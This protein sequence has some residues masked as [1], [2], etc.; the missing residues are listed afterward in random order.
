M[1]DKAFYRSRRIRGLC[2]QCGKVAPLWPDGTPK[3]KCAECTAKAK[4]LRSS[5]HPKKDDTLCWKCKHSVPSK[6]GSRGCEWSRSRQPVEGW[7]AKETSLKIMQEVRIKSYVVRKCPKF[8][9]G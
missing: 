9:K 7:E 3:V 4:L 6:D 1:G 8:E 5:Y 2:V